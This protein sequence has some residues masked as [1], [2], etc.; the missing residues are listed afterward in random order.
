MFREDLQPERALFNGNEPAAVA[1]PNVQQVVTIPD[2][3]RKFSELASGHGFIDLVIESL[4]WATVFQRPHDALE[5]QP[6]SDHASTRFRRANVGCRASHERALNEL[7]VD[8]H[9]PDTKPMT[10]SSS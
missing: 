6:G 5:A 7:D 8:V 9:P 4:Q 3:P 1:S 2:C 10:A